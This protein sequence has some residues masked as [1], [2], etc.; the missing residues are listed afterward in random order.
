MQVELTQDQR[1]AKVTTLATAPGGLRTER[2]ALPPDPDLFD[3]LVEH[4]VDI[5]VGA[6]LAHGS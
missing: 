1:I 5:E 3:H 4:G 6:A 2:V